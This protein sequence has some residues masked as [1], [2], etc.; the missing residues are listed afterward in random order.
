MLPFTFDLFGFRILTYSALIVTS[1]VASSIYFIGYVRTYVTVRRALDMCL[2]LWIGGYI[3]GRMLFIALDFEYFAT[4]NLTWRE[5]LFPVQEGGLRWHGVLI[6]VFIAALIG[7][8]WLRVP[9]ERVISACLPALPLIALGAW[10]ACMAV[11]CGYGIEVD[12]LAHYPPLV[13][14]ETR[15]VYGLVAPRYF[16]QGYG[17]VLALG[18]AGWI[19]VTARKA[20]ISM[21]SPFWRVVTAF[22]VGMFI[23]GFFRA[24]PEPMLF[25]LRVEQVGDAIIAA[26]SITLCVYRMNK[27]SAQRAFFR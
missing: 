7:A 5:W 15:D 27:S 19:V 23:I 20:S 25:G 14:A 3:G 17:V 21:H 13:V 1:L 22:A 4:A 9:F 24:E 18:L 16:T 11:G 6:G 10:S 2:L 8:R 12:T 26:F